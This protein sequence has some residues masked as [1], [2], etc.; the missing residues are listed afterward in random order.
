MFFV[1][2][3]FF[4]FVLLLTAIVNAALREKVL[5]P[6][7]E[8]ALGK[9]AHQLSVF[10]ALILMFAMT[11]VFLRMQSAPYDAGDLWIVGM[12]WCMMTVIFEFGFGMARGMRFRELV[13]M[14][15]FWKGE[16]WLF[17]VLGLI[18][19]PTLANKLLK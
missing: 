7:F 6:L 10:T 13:A 4:W 8:P 3:I 18:A 15:H 12:T 2:A 5:K 9:W 14:Y 16:L 19:L 17:L 1:Y 11:M